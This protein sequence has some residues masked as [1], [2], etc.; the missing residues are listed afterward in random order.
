AQAQ[1]PAPNV[2]LGSLPYAYYQGSI[3]SGQETDVF[4]QSS[5]QDFLITTAI[6]SSLNC[7]L[8]QDNTLLVNGKAGPMAYAAR[9]S[10]FLGT[11]IL[12]VDAGS[13]LTVK[14]VGDNCA[15]HISGYHIETGG[16]Y[17]SVTGSVNPNSSQSVLTVA[18]GK[19]FVLRSVIMGGN[20]PETC[21]LYI[22]GSMIL[23][24]H[25]HAMTRE[26][27]NSAFTNGNIRIPVPEN[28]SL[29]VKN[30][31]SS[32]ECHYHIEG[33]YAD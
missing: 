19:T 2:S 13:T 8:Y 25:L 27:V 31:G 1:D 21:D 12:R 29:V 17:A 28:D 30:T 23:E 18:A 6:Q 32:S 16:P 7:D 22:N 14:A 15:F 24:G 10:L 9:G 20:Q 5:D 4:T 11:G 3:L 26:G 33:I